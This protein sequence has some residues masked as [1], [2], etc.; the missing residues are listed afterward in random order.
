MKRI[1]QPV[2]DPDPL[3]YKSG[4]V[5]HTQNPINGKPREPDDFQ[6]RT[7]IRNQ[8]DDGQLPT[9]QEIQSFCQEFAVEPDLVKSYILHLQDLRIRADIGEREREEQKK[10]SN[11]ER[12]NQSMIM[13][14]ISWL[15]PGEPEKL[16]VPELNKYLVHHGLSTQGEKPEKLR[17]RFF[18]TNPNPD[19][20]S[21]NGFFVSFAKSK[22]G[23]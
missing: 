21:K 9:K 19:S 12:R 18:G 8:R 2:S 7:N 3:H 1:P 6:P 5:T 16:R 10:K 13:I 20:E 14:G 11:N 4:D 15:T 23:L 17:V 22:K